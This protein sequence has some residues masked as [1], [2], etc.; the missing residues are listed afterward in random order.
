MNATAQSAAPVA[1][2]SRAASATTAGTGLAGCAAA[3]RLYAGSVDDD[4]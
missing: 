2:G 1:S 4:E 3:A